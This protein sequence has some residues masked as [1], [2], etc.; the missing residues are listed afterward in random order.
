M[1]DATW[2][3]R[4]RQGA[5]LFGTTRPPNAG[6]PMGPAGGARA[7]GDAVHDVLRIE[8]KSNFGQAVRTLWEKVHA[9]SKKPAVLILYQKRKHGALIVFH[10]NDLPTVLDELAE[11]LT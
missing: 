10:E 11:T 2:K 6:S 1:S 8:T 3:R 9:S 4:E 5:A 7:D